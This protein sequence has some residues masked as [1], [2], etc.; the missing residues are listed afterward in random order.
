VTIQRHRRP[1][2]AGWSTERQPEKRPQLAAAAA[3]EVAVV[4]SLL[5]H[6]EYQQRYH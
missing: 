1:R 5:F 6:L 4:V 3:V 2:W